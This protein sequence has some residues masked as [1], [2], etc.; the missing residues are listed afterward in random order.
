MGEVSTQLADS[1][2]A[3]GRHDAQLRQVPAPR[4][5]GE[6]LRVGLASDIAEPARDSPRASKRL[7]W[8]AAIN[9]AAQPDKEGRG[10]DA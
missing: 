5:A 3:L 10:E 4:D 2:A 9:T 1:I 7:S 8:S 6:Y